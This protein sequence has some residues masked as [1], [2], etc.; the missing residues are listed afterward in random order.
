MLLSFAAAVAAS[1]RRGGER[2][3]TRTSRQQ[4]TKTKYAIY[5]FRNSKSPATL[6]RRV[7]LCRPQISDKLRKYQLVITG[8][9][10]VLIAWGPP[11][12]GFGITFHREA[13]GNIDSELVRPRTPVGCCALNQFDAFHSRVSLSNPTGITG[14]AVVW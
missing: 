1:P 11:T 7:D 6:G 9:D 10:G 8:G 2:G 14:G 13:N 12:H 5:F 3:A 4:S